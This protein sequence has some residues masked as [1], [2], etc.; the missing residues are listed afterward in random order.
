MITHSHF[1][2]WHAHIPTH[3]PVPPCTLRHL[4]IM[5]RGANHHWNPCRPRT[6]PADIES[7]SRKSNT[8]MITHSH[9]K[10]CHAHIPTHGPIPS[11]ASARCAPVHHQCQTADRSSSNLREKNEVK[12]AT[13]RWCE[14][15]T[16]KETHIIS[17]HE[18]A[19]NKRSPQRDTPRSSPSKPYAS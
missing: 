19:N 11:A 2:Q 13:L 12:K 16:T 10:Q 9:F 17:R 7:K 4:H 8:E 1:E 15:Q 14:A 5:R 3:V 6:A 18:R